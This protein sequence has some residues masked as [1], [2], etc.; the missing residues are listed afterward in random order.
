M[1]GRWVIAALLLVAA[2]AEE[3]KLYRVGQTA[4]RD[5]IYD[6][7]ERQFAEFLQKFPESDQAE[8]AQLLLTQAQLSQNKWREA[9]QTAQAALKKWPEG[10]QRDS[11]QFWL[12]ESLLRGDEYAAAEKQYAELLEKTPH[13][14][15]RAA[16]HYGLAFAQFKQG[17]SDAATATLERL[18][19]L[20]P[21]GD[22]AQESELLRGQIQ[23]GLEKF[24]KAD[25]VFEALIK[26]FPGTRASYRAQSWLGE[27]L[28]R[29]GQFE[30]AL[31]RYAAV[32]EAFK[33]SPNKP[34]TAPVAA[35]AW[36]GAGWAYWNQGRFDSAADAFA[37]TLALAQSP[38]LKRDAL[39]KLGEAHVRAG[40]LADGV[41]RLKA[42]LQAHP[43]DPLAG[44]VQMAIGDLLFGAG[45]FAAALPEYAALIAKFPGSPALAR[46][47]LQ[48]GWCAWNLGSQL[49][50]ALRYFQQA[51]ALAKDQAEAVEALF[52]VGDTQF[53]LGRYQDAAE[54]Y[55]QLIGQFP[56]SKLVERTMF[57]LGQ[58]YQRLRDADAAGNVFRSLIEKFPDGTL[59]PEAQFQIGLI[60]A[61]QNREESARAAFLEAIRRYPESEWAKRA[62]LAIGESFYREGK[63]DEAA[64]EFE[65]LMA[66]APGTE[67][68]QRAFY[69]R[70]WCYFSKGQPEKAL[71]EFGS[72]L[73]QYPQS[74]LAPDVQF[75][76][77]DYFMKQKDYIKAQEN[78]QCVAKNYPAS[79][80]AD[81]A[82]YMAGRSAYLRQD[83]KAALELYEA[84]L[85]TFPESSWCCDAR[86][87]EGD[88]LS[89]LGRFDDALLVFDSLA[90]QF[91]D[92]Y[93]ACDAHGRKADCLFTLGRFEDAV[94]AYRKAL[95]CA[96]D[97]EPAFRNQLYY[98]LGQSFEK[99]GKLGDAFEWYSKAIYEQAAAPDPTAPPERFWSCKAGL[100]AGSVKE[101]QQQWREAIALYQR[102][103]E[104]CPDLKPLLDERSRR[105]R[106]ERLIL[107]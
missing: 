48:A 42:F 14:A 75:W 62:A 105:I 82:Q 16:G 83:Y 69:H 102:M 67:L 87:G 92:C 94:A 95:D 84:L 81:T 8:T 27:S 52:K 22:V 26:N 29:R 100:A 59:A 93:L 74:A 1:R 54:S 31:K 70:G 97:A 3:T 104:Q 7:A 63:C 64:S 45:D 55:R 15:H 40:K 99:A 11:F 4:F 88:A 28:A 96:R 6:L 106:V 32:T 91:P 60:E 39:L 72:F 33:A 73:K 101:Q 12:A 58:S 43:A 47:N 79:K 25:A 17:R 44:D 9:G 21:K 86:F 77:A 20:A 13:T 49:P 41:A 66:A 51:L 34:V 61:G 36:Y 38:R 23:L 30:E 65:K 98:K 57:Q 78:F 68:A 10:R 107:F 89:E 24:D 71:S 37:Q 50:E 19:R 35:E 46:A 18:A 56:D 5:G 53:A 76:V 103:A 90:K 85:K 2:T 80:L